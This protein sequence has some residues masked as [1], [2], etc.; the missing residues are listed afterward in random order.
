MQILAYIGNTYPAH[1]YSHTKHVYA[2]VD[3]YVCYS[4]TYSE[5]KY[6]KILKEITSRL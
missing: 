5:R 3:T 1:T 4:H 2:Y 6:T